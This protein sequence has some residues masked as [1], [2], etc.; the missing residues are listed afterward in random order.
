[1]VVTFPQIPQPSNLVAWYEEAI[2]HYLRK[3]TDT[4]IAFTPHQVAQMFV[5]SKKKTAGHKEVSAAELAL[6]RLASNGELFC[7][8]VKG[9]T[10]YIND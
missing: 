1:M 6:K 8:E 10:L 4:L 5:L 2:T 7:H 9:E 3:H